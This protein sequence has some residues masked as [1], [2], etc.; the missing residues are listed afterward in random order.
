MSRAAAA[1]PAHAPLPQPA[2]LVPPIY[3]RLLRMLLQH[4]DVDGDRVLAAAGLDWPTL[5]TD[6]RR[7]GLATVVRLAES[8]MAATRRPWLGL[9]LGGS[10]PVSAHGA[11]GY[12]A[13]TSRDLREALQVIARYGTTRN[14][15]MAWTCVETATG[16][17][18]RATERTELGAVRAFVVDTTLAAV[19]RMIEAAVGAVPPGLRV[20]LP[21]PVPPWREQYQRFGLAELRFGQPAFAFHVDARELALPCIG[22]DAKAHAN[23]CRE[24]EEALAE[25]RGASMAQRV[26]GLL[27]S[28]DGGAYPRMAELAARCGISPRTLIR[29][30]HDDGTTFQALL[31]AARQQRALWMLQHTDASVEEIAARLGYQDT[32]NFSRTVRRW[33]GATPREL[34]ERPVRAA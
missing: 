3:A 20:D 2:S 7:L 17:S 8:A 10:A 1:H 32:S 19:L 26:A 16:L 22:A 31:D 11:L 24:C 27:A 21:L 5:V 34:R 33:F 25:V 9:D 6:D 28:V 12:A 30:L 18:M 4:A 13:V 14:D 29:R 23:A 15:A